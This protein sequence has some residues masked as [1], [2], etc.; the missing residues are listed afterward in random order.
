[1]GRRSGSTTARPTRLAMALRAVRPP[2]RTVALAANRRPLPRRPVVRG[3]R[4]LAADVAHVAG[5][6]SSARRACTCDPQRRKDSIYG[7]TSGALAAVAEASR[8]SGTPCALDFED[9]HCGE[10][11]P[12]I[13]ETVRDRLA[14]SVM[15]DAISQAAFITVGSAAIARACHER[16]GAIC[17]TINNVFPLP[18]E[19]PDAAGSGPLRVDRFG[20]TIGPGR[21][22][23]DVVYA[24]SRRSRNPGRR[25][26]AG[27]TRSTV[28]LA[29]GSPLPHDRSTPAAGPSQ[30]ERSG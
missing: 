1:M 22:L 27:C 11:S 28:P 4:R 7:G 29:A 14:A 18:D 21:G 30:P 13:G 2:E 15:A 3:D 16:F 19:P 25:A 8:R 23:K 12:R 17:T 9:F 5:V 26:P 20:Q 24:I 10:Q 6:L